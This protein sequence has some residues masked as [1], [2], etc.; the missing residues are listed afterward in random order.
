[1]RIIE[2]GGLG[3]YA[4]NICRRHHLAQNQ[5]CLARWRWLAPTGGVAAFESQSQLA[6]VAPDA[7]GSHVNIDQPVKEM[8]AMDCGTLG[9]GSRTSVQNVGFY[10]VV[11]AQ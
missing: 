11:E 6:M 7:R 3:W 5:E 1:M 8:I 9:C 4:V 10:G 2:H